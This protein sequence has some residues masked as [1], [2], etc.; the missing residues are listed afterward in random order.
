M[1][2]A[3]QEVKRRRRDDGWLCWVADRAGQFWDFVDKRQ[4]D[5]Y[6]VS[7]FILYGTLEIMRWAMKFAEAHHDK[8]G[9][10]IAAIIAAIVTP[11]SALQAAAIKFL[12]EARKGSFVP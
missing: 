7:V 9:I 6:F 3:P 1:A 10:E 5:A 2:E 11:Y 4:I 8:S 12:F